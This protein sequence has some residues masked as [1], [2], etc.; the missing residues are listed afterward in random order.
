MTAHR[1][2]FDELNQA[3]QHHT[4]C[5]LTMETDIDGELCYALRDGCDDPMGDYFYDLIDVEDYITNNADIHRHLY[6]PA[7]II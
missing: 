7:P 1:F 4:P 6:G 3:V 5:Y 2:N